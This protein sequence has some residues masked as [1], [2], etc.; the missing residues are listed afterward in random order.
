MNLRPI[1]IGICG[2]K[3]HGKDTLAKLVC[4]RLPRSKKTAFADVLKDMAAEIFELP[5]EIFHDQTMKEV[6]LGDYILLD[7]Y[8]ARMHAATG[9]PIKPQG[10][11]A[12]TPREL[13][14]YFGTEYV[15]RADNSYWVRHTL[16][17]DPTDLKHLVVSDVR[18]AD[19]ARAVNDRNGLTVRLVRTDLPSSGDKHVSERLDFDCDMTLRIKTGE[20]DKL[21]AYASGIVA[22][23]LGI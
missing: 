21:E 13:I 17:Q 6:F 5:V 2:E 9:L 3:G 8:L 4:Q 16:T 14:Q 12:G 15:R 10:K 23:A 7:N 20:F 1:Y 19:E 22:T 18:F 11:A